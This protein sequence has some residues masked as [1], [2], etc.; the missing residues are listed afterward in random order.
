MKATLLVLSLLLTAC[1]GQVPAV[2]QVG[3]AA[4]LQS[5]QLYVLPFETVMVPTEVADRLFSAFIDRV[6]E[7]GSAQGYEFIILKQGVKQ[8]D[9]AWLE[10]QDYL[11][12]ELFAYV[13]DIGSSVS[14]IKARSRLLLFQPGREAASLELNYAAE[15][16]YE[17]D[18]SSLAAERLRLAEEVSSQLA[19]QLLKAL[20]ES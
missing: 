13:E 6:N 16:F 18:Y 15:A 2:K 12:G 9:P 10:Q 7:R 8:I 20:S 5:R 14:V 19:E 1:L 3:Q 4:P 11:R 17:N